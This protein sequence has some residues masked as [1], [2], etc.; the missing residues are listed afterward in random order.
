MA[1]AAPEWNEANWMLARFLCI[2]RGGHRW[3]TIEDPAGSFQRCARCGTLGHRRS[4]APTEPQEYLD[5]PT[6][7][8]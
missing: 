4:G 3:E 2:V 5:L 1:T 7:D 8:S 6:R